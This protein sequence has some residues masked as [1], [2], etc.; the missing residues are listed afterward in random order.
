MLFRNRGKAHSE[1]VAAIKT[2]ARDL[3]PIPEEAAV[4]VTEL[5]CHEEGCPPVETVIAALIEGEAPRQWKMHK[6]IASVSRE[7]IAALGS[8]ASDCGI[9]GWRCPD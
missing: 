8:A 4:M 6:G 5:E 7:D 1:Q 2:W 9:K 3:L